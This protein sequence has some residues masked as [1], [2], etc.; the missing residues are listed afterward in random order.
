MN[1]CELSPSV[2]VCVC[3]HSTCEHVSVRLCVWAE[4][5]GLHVSS[6]Q[7]SNGLQ[8]ALQFA[9]LIQ[10]SHVTAAPHTLLP[11]EHPRHLH[12]HSNKH[13]QTH[14]YPPQVIVGTVEGG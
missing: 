2:C 5:L 4:T 11:D 3:M 1:V 6:L 10:I 9:T 12:R 8:H 14:Y 7:R 13:T